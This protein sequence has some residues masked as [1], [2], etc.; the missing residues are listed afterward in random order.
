MVV[1]PTISSDD[2]PT[3]LPTLNFSVNYR[4][5]YKN[6]A[7]KQLYVRT[8]ATQINANCHATQINYDPGTSAYKAST[9]VDGTKP[10]VFLNSN[11]SI[12]ISEGSLSGIYKIAVSLIP[13]S[14]SIEI[15][16]RYYDQYDES[17]SIDPPG[18]LTIQ[19][20]YDN[21]S[22]IIKAPASKLD[23]T[24]SIGGTS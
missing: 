6:T 15:S 11:T 17:I 2:S 1:N 21:L 23:Y 16:I 7:V 19:F 8:T 4:S 14:D 10:E 22:G 24:I 5:D 9:I 12:I 18:D 20:S 13:T 3:D